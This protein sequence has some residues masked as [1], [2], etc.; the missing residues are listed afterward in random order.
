MGEM[1]LSVV[2]LSFAW[3]CMVVSDFIDI[4]SLIDSGEENTLTHQLFIE[5]AKPPELFIGSSA[6]HP[7]ALI[8]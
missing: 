7:H 4:P 6:D 2:V 3:I 5:S 8:D 1:C